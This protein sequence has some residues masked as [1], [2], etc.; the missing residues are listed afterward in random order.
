MS[1]VFRINPGFF[2][3]AKSLRAVNGVSLSI[4]KGQVVGLVGEVRLWQVDLG[5]YSLGPTKAD[6]G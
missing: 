6:L 3:G 4:P 1:C 5:Q 2:K